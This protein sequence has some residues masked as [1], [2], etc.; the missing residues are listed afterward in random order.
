[1]TELVNHAPPNLTTTPIDRFQISDRDSELRRVRKEVVEGG[2]RFTNSV[3]SP[4]GEQ[5]EKVGNWTQGEKRGR[6]SALWGVA[7]TL[8]VIGTGGPGIR[9]WGVVCTLAVTGTGWAGPHSAL[10]CYSRSSESRTVAVV[11]S[12]LQPLAA[13][14]YEI[15]ET[16]G[17]FSGEMAY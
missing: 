5:W 17:L 12:L 14:G 15:R 2:A 7:C 1:M 6:V 10:A 8:V 9:L 4:R 3:I 16:I 13:G 11:Y